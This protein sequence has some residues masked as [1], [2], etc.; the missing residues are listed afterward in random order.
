VIVLIK[1]AA[2]GFKKLLHTAANQ[3][4]C[5]QQQTGDTLGE[6]E[7]ARNL[8]FQLSVLLHHQPG[9]DLSNE[10]HITDSQG[11]APGGHRRLLPLLHVGLSSA[12]WLRSKPPELEATKRHP[13]G[14]PQLRS[15]WPTYFVAH[16]DSLTQP[17]LQLASSSP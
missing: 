14:H 2:S 16:P 5:L 11:L 1:P 7:D 12:R 17:F 8:E 6:D 4:F 10:S 13:A 15:P 9:S 3:F